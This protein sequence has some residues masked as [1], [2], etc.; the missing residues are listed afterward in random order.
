MGDDVKAMPDERLLDY[1][2]CIE[3]KIRFLN[4][5]RHIVLAT[6]LND[7]VTART[8]DYVCSGL[9]L[10][11]LSWDHHDKITQINGNHRVALCR[12]NVQ[13]EG[14]A[15]IL[16][17][18]HDDKNKEYAELYRG[19]LPILFDVFSNLPGMIF[20]KVTSK[21]F[22]TFI[23]GRNRRIDYLDLSTY[24]AFWKGLE[25]DEYTQGT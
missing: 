25:E 23:S 12:D 8:I 20:V 15:E 7:R 19:K 13:I 4:D 17:N 14:V 21:L 18:P 1:D 2:K 11:F 24:R 22:K 5:D 16:G 9:D 10:I 3:E 6:S